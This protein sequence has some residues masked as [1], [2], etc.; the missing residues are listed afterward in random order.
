MV[1]HGLGAE[2]EDRSIVWGIN[3]FPICFRRGFPRD[4][5]FWSRE[6]LDLKSP[7]MGVFCPLRPVRSNGNSL[8]ETGTHTEHRNTVFSHSS[9]RS[10]GISL[11][12]NDQYDLVFRS[13]SVLSLTDAD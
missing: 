5:P 7:A 1:C 6:T 13:Q 12:Q 10:P 2:S 8:I 11:E 3:A 4:S 9:D